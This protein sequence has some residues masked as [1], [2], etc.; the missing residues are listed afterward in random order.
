MG[1]SAFQNGALHV[2]LGDG[3]VG[4][5]VQT[6]CGVHAI[7]FA[8]IDKQEIGA[9]WPGNWGQTVL[10]ISFSNTE[11]INV[12]AR[13]IQKLADLPMPEPEGVWLASPPTI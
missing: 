1:V 10:V 4:V 11:S 12:M 5:A 8:H 13:A 7:I 6:V 2:S 9:L 3:D